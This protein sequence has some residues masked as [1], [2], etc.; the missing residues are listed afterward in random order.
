MVLLH[1]LRIMAVGFLMG[2]ADL[3]P[4]VSGGTIAFVCG[5]YDRFIDGLKAFDLNALRMILRLDWRGLDRKIPLVFFACLGS[6]LLLAVFTLS[7]VLSAL[8]ANHPVALWSFF[9]GLV[10]GSILLLAKVTWRWRPAEWIAFGAAAVGT[11]WLVGLPVTQTPPTLPFV[12]ISGAIAICAMILPGISGSYLLVILGKYHQILEAVNHRDFLTL[13]VFVAGIV[14]GVMSFA[15]VV[16][17][18]LHSYR[19][20]TLVALTGVMAGALRTVWPWKETIATRINSKGEE[21]PLMQVNIL[22]SE[23]ST[24]LTALL[25]FVAGAA[26]VLLLSRLAPPSDRLAS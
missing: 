25:L 1:H 3:I 12:F 13:G 5:I 10:T 26:V 2:A 19:R 14:A 7:R 4:G 20:T 8:F 17:W 9:F 11:Y 23:S 18:L 16:S 21:V 24:I 15:R 22:P 6:G